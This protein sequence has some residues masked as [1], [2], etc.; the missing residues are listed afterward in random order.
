MNNDM[1]RRQQGKGTTGS[2]FDLSLIQPGWGR[3]LQFKTNNI[4]FFVENNFELTDRLSVSP[5]IR[6]EMGKSDLG[7]S[8]T[9]YPHE[10]LPATIDHKF[11]LLESTL[12]THLQISSI[13]MRDGRKLIAR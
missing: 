2:D 5:G 13:C 6:A 1:H 8:I 9:Y 4:A 3:D 10:Q 12:N 7:G 11:V